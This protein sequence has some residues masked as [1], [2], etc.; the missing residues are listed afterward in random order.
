M[1]FIKDDGTDRAMEVA[2]GRDDNNRNIKMNK[3]N[4][5]AV[6][7]Q[8]DIIYADEYPDDPKKGEFNEKYGLYVERPFHIVSELKGNRYLDLRSNRY[9]VTN[10]RSK[11]VDQIWYFDQKSLTIRSK[12]ANEQV[13]AIERSGTTNN[14]ETGRLLDQQIWH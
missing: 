11:S 2:E 3:F 14:M 1:N 10:S 5:D 8:W 13:F 7:Q 9:M 12:N 6:H 4:K